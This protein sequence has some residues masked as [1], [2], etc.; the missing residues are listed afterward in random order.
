MILTQAVP[1]LSH[2]PP[3]PHPPFAATAKHYPNL[4]PKPSSS[5]CRTPASSPETKAG[6]DIPIDPP[7]LMAPGGWGQGRDGHSAGDSDGGALAAGHPGPGLRGVRRFLPRRS[8]THTRALHTSRPTFPAVSLVRCSPAQAVARSIRTP[9]HTHTN[10]HTHTR[11][12][13]LAAHRLSPSFSAICF[14]AVAADILLLPTRV[15]SNPRPHTPN[16]TQDPPVSVGFPII[17]EP[18]YRHRHY[19]MTCSCT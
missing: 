10:V 5:S 18:T 9:T 1:P 3:F 16:S 11:L 13:S 15:P 4:N 12:V 2:C 6:N 8:D 17:C 7:G 19:A 14:Q